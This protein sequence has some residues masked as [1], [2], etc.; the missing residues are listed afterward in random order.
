MI[1]N[2]RLSE[3]IGKCYNYNTPVWEVSGSGPGCQS[4]YRNDDLISNDIPVWEVSGSGPGCH[5]GY[6]C[7]DL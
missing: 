4:G 1:M 2:A 5:S 7:G 6:S 3:N